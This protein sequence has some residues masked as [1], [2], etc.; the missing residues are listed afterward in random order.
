MLEHVRRLGSMLWM[1]RITARWNSGSASSRLTYLASVLLTVWPA[2]TSAGPRKKHGTG[3]IQRWMKTREILQVVLGTPFLSP[4]RWCLHLT[5]DIWRSLA[6]P[7]SPRKSRLS[8]RGV[9]RTPP[10]QGV[11]GDRRF[12]HQHYLHVA[13]I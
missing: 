5:A 13:T 8:G 3:N 9:S 1:S 12:A 11:P 10:P 6:D 2:P 7:H 4:K